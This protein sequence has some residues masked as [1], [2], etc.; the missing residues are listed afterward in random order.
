MHAT[1]EHISGPY[2]EPPED[3]IDMNPEGESHEKAC[4]AERL[5]VMHTA[6]HIASYKKG[7]RL[8]A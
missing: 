1:Y 4:Y 6:Y 8:L 2:F 3:M 5:E 7:K